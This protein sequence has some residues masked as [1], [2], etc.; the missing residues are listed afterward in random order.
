MFVFERDST[1]GAFKTLY[2]V[3]KTSAFEKE[4]LVWLFNNTLASSSGDLSSAQSL[5]GCVKPHA[6]PETSGMYFFCLASFRNL[7]TSAPAELH[8][9]SSGPGR[10]I[11]P[12][13][14]RAVGP[15]E[16]GTGHPTPTVC[17]G[18]VSGSCV[19]GLG[20]SVPCGGS[21]SSHAIMGH[22]N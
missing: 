7:H 4:Y 2:G 17:D 13:Y 14:H 11:L 21:E 22:F 6:C 10:V 9:L 19:R 16:E 3:C 20:I 15:I 18:W 5:Q 1:S 8:S 12:F